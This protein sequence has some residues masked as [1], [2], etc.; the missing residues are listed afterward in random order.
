MKQSAGQK[1]MWLISVN[2]LLSLLL[3]LS[4][5]G[6]DKG[7]EGTTPAEGT[8]AGDSTVA[9]RS[10]EVLDAIARGEKENKVVLIELYDDTC[11]FCIDMD[12]V[13]KKKYIKEALAGLVHVRVT[14]ED[15]KLIEEFGLTQSP[16]Y[17]FFKP[18]S[19]YMGPYLDGYRSSKRFVAEINNFILRAEGKPELDLEED[20]HPNFGKG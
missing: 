4:C 17:L 20:M 19:E 6:P 3:S 15:E 13:L 18:D 7:T 12:K 11:N 16:T 14:I 1:T 9:P 10:Q 2:I 8:E 5:C